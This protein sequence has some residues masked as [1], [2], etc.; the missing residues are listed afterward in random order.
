MQLWLE[1]FSP[2]MLGSQNRPRGASSKTQEAAAAAAT[3]CVLVVVVGK[4]ACLSLP[5]IH[6]L[7]TRSSTHFTQCL[8]TQVTY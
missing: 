3:H 8:L 2:T 7:V 4:A 6:V 5:Q 1:T